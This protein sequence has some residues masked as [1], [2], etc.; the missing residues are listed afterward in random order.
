M[1][2]ASTFVYRERPGF[3][4]DPFLTADV[5][6][7]QVISVEDP[8]N[9]AR[10]ASS[11]SAGLYEQAMQVAIANVKALSDAGVTIAMGTDTGPMGRFQGY[12]E[13]HELGVMVEGGLTPA[14]ALLS[15][16]RDAARCI[17]RPD[18]GTLEPGN[19]ADFVVFEADPLADIANT[20]TR[21]L[22]Y[23]GGR[24]VALPGPA[25]P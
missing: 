19:W 23:V 12:F 21:E 3:M 5:D 10:V 14:Q 16:T 24:E 6:S 18:L 15:A 8:E 2:E 13:H 4:D 7:A 25:V 9:Q 22:V 1:R 11:R 17:G 20:R